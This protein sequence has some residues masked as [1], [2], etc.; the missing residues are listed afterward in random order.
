MFKEVSIYTL[1]PDL[2]R[3]INANNKT[4]ENYLNVFY[5]GSSNTLK[6]PLSTTGSIKGSRGEFVTVVADSLI[7]KKQYTNMYENI[8]TTNYDWYN[9]YANGITVLRDPSTWD[10]S[11]A[12]DFKYIDVDKP[13]YKVYANNNVG[14]KCTVVSQM[15]ELII[16]PSGND[17]FTVLLDPSGSTYTTSTSI[18]PGESVTLICTGYDPSAGSTWTVMNTSGGGAKSWNIL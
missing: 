16:D 1:M 2:F 13:Y 15:V 11:I 4:V 8:T 17:I 10:P 12:G 14:L 5:D 18:T 3:I 9:A 7:V 6:S